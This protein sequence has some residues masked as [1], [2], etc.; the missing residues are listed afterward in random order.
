MLGEMA[1]KK[2]GEENTMI[3]FKHLNEKK[4]HK[5]HHFVVDK[6]NECSVCGVCGLKKVRK[7]IGW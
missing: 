4:P 3:T 5:F 7:I 1:M 6:S 2:N